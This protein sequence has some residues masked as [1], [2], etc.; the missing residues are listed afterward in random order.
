MV[1]NIVL[2]NARNTRVRL[3]LR[4][5][6]DW[7]ATVQ[8]PSGEI[9]WHCNG[10]TD[11][12][13]HVEAAMGLTVGEYLEEAR[14]AYRWLAACQLSDGSWYAAYRN[15]MA[16]DFTRDTNFSA[17]IA[18]GLFHYYL[19][20]DD[21]DFLAEMWPTMRSAINFALGLQAPGGEIYWAVSPTGQTD[22]MALL[23]GSSAI[24]MSLKCGEAIAALLGQPVS[25]WHS[26]RKRLAF[27][28]RHRPHHFNMTKSRFSMD[29]FYPILSGAI[30]GDDARRRIHRCW[31]KFMVKGEGVRCVSDK[32]WITIAET[33]ELVLALEAMGS[34]EQAQVVFDWICDRRFSDG[35]YWC[36]YNIPEL[37][38]WP[39]ERMT[40]TN[41]AML[42]AADSLYDL[43]PAGRLF[44]HHFWEDAP[45][46]K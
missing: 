2:N 30:T 34:R 33:A 28:I 19:R 22:T 26:A 25:E 27:A 3:D 39:D 17:Y 5:V 13:D 24:H 46:R 9:P 29:W 1:L 4:P 20:T 41:A 37:E 44:R 35:T 43:T 14:R 45:S 11:P 38:I 42:L 12:W 18:V 32:P 23:T 10:K 16:E 36:G 31:K 6:A 15:G 7:I 8:Q 21:T 40:W